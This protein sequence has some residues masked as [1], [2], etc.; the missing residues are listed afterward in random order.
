MSG[1]AGFLAKRGTVRSTSQSLIERMTA[2][3]RHRG[4]DAGGVWQSR[5]GQ[6][7]LGHRR[8][9]ILDLT[10]TGAQPMATHDGRY[11]VTYNGEIYNFSE[12]RSE[13]E[14]LGRR[15]IGT[16]DTEVLLHAVA[17]WGVEPSLRRFNGM[18]AFA[19]WDEAEQALYLARDRFGE[20]PLYYSWQ[21]GDFVFGSELKALVEHPSFRREVDPE[22]VALFLRFNYVPW[23]RSIYRNTY[24]LGPGQFL[25]VEPGR[26]PSAPRAYW[27]LQELVEQRAPLAIDPADPA[28]AEVVDAAMRTAVKLRMVSDVPLGAFLSGGI[29]SSL[30][31]AMMQL[32][33][34][35]PVKTF[36]IGFWEAPYNEAE[37]AARIAHHLGTEHHELYLSSQQCINLIKDLPTTYDEPFADSSQIP[38]LLVSEFTRR[39]VTVALS[40]DAG[41]ELFG[42]YNRYFWSQRI[43][44]KL[45]RMSVS[46]RRRMA[47]G[48]LDRTPSEWDRVFGFAN[49]VVPAKF[50]VRGGGEKLHKLARAM[51]ARNSDEL[52]RGFVSQWHDPS[53]VLFP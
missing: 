16:S 3:L 23:P 52:Y 45:L 30:V 25:R 4:P 32:Q 18:F 11:V 39:H 37:D 26:E 27:S 53:K 46:M 1:I 33:S 48:I 14:G 19:L 13:L 12:I 7:N 22:S 42:G 47:S 6:V 24:K 36:T 10:P 2:S 5:D 9:S 8:L 43:W 35:R 34:S 20:K 50:R 51:D 41:D 38:T 40:G 17:Q 44:P 15:F 31:V 29:D 21:N 49:P 28:L